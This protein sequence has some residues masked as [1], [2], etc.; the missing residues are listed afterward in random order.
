MRTINATDLSK[1]QCP[2][3]KRAD[4]ERRWDGSRGG[5]YDDIHAKAYLDT[6][7]FLPLDRKPDDQ[8]SRSH[9]TIPA[10]SRLVS[11]VRPAWRRELDK[12]SVDQMIAA[13]SIRVGVMQ[14]LGPTRHSCW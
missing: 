9:C 5:K 8:A 6:M 14:A 3:Y 10:K 4:A 2:N 12:D 13:D 11:A 7:G 1:S